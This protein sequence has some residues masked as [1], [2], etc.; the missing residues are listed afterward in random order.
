MTAKDG[1]IQ[2]GDWRVLVDCPANCS[3]P[4]LDH[5]IHTCDGRGRNAN[6]FGE[7]PLCHKKLNKGLV[8]IFPLL[9]G[10]SKL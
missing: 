2:I 4:A 10:L 5:F 6:S 9:V 3:I 1:T 8:E 7:C